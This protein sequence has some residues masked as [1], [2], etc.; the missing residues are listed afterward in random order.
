MRLIVRGE[1]E[2]PQVR[3]HGFLAIR[4]VFLCLESLLVLGHLAQVVTTG[5]HSLCDALEAQLFRTLFRAVRSRAGH[6]G[7]SAQV[8]AAAVGVRG[9]ATRWVARTI[10]WSP[11]CGDFLLILVSAP[12]TVL[13]ASAYSTFAIVKIC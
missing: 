11:A 10:F 4:Q 9:S 8:D 5:G 6:A 13:I 7:Q 12:L 2:R 3:F 1:L